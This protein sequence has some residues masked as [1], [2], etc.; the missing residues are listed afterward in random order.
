M[1]G[2]QSAG[3]RALSERTLSL[4]VVVY[5]GYSLNEKGQSALLSVYTFLYLSEAT[6]PES[7]ALKLCVCLAGG[8]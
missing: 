1:R 4:C 6:K 5:H 8:L 3:R 2:E 7:A